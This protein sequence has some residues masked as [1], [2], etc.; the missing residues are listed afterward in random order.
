MLQQII[1]ITTLKDMAAFYRI[2]WITIMYL[3]GFGLLYYVYSY[4]SKRFLRNVTRTL[5]RHTFAGIFRQNYVDFTNKNTADYISALTNDMKLVEENYILPMLLTLQYVVTFCVTLV[6]LLY[7]SPFVTVCLIASMALMFLSPLLFG[8]ALE[9]RQDAVSEKLSVF[10]GRIK[11]MFQGYEVIQ[12]FGIIG[13]I[14]KKFDEENQATAE[15]KFCADRLFVLN[16]SVSQ[17][18]AMVSQVLAV[19]VSAYLVITGHITMGTLIAIV[20][21]CATFVMPIVM[22]MENIPKITSMKPVLNRLDD[23]VNY[24]DMDFNGKKLPGFDR[25]IALSDVRFGY[26]E[27]QPVLQ[28]VSAVIQK[29]KKYAVVGRSG[30]GKTTLVKLLMDYYSRFEGDITYDG[31]PITELDVEKLREMIS[32]IHQN[33]YM[34]DTT[35]REN[36]GLYREYPKEKWEWVLRVS[37]VDEFLAELPEGLNAQAGEN[38][39]NLSGG[40]RQRIAIARALIQD[41]PILV[42]DEGTS[43]I[44]M[45]TAYDIESKLLEVEDLTVITIT[46]KMSEELLHMYDQIL[47]MDQGKIV[48]AGTLNELTAQKGAF[49]EF[50][51]LKR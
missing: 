51:T 6:V 29:G 7:L 50:Y 37:G 27:G 24:T 41:T 36:I 14:Q 8:K 21:L 34:F 28:G 39:E 38:G 20:Q 33:V 16:E 23:Y 18:L 10:T 11:D 25:E 48:E 40:Q 35:I 31:I 13:M 42:L 47:L 1:D 2:I 44:D 15:V 32:G 30:C 19:F 26:T 46:H 5:R 17:M 43:A 45:Q 3:A 49:W 22:I 4:C 12:S 9:K